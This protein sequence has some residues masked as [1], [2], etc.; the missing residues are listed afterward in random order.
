[1]NCPPCNGSCNQGR[2]CERRA[3][4]QADVLWGRPGRNSVLQYSPATTHHGA[5]AGG[6]RVLVERLLHLNQRV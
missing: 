1:M 5:V 2:N 4:A 3:V 6:W